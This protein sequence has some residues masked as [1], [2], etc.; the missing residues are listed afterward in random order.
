MTAEAVR[1]WESYAIKT[2][3]DRAED[4]GCPKAAEEEMDGAV[5]AP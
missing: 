4:D 2:V 3:G 1:V 5:L